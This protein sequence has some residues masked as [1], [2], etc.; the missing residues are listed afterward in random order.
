MNSHAIKL[1]TIPADN[2]SEDGSA[3]ELAEP[4]SARS[5]TPS[6][7]P[8][9][10]RNQQPD[11][12]GRRS[13]RPYCYI[14]SAK[15]TPLPPQ[16]REKLRKRQCFSPAFDPS[17]NRSVTFLPLSIYAIVFID[18]TERQGRAPDTPQALHLSHLGVASVSPRRCNG[19]AKALHLSA[20]TP[21]FPI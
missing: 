2:H 19:P 1:H 9:S 18:F 11:G 21:F 3:V 20:G 17:T 12:Q 6:A 14:S 8:V 13:G 15:T 7:V 10:S 5:L 4:A 16:P